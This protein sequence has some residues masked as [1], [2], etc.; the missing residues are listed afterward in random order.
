M[1]SKRPFTWFCSL[2]RVNQ[3]QTCISGGDVRDMRTHRQQR[4]RRFGCIAAAVAATAT[5]EAAVVGWLQLG[6]LWQRK[7]KILSS[8]YQ[9][10]TDR[11]LPYRNRRKVVESK[12]KTQ[13]IQLKQTS[14]KYSNLTW[15]CSSWIYFGGILTKYFRNDFRLPYEGMK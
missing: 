12:R 5:A 10:Q 6:F 14:N 13:S 7:V 8:E 3:L 1:I 4:S 2:L 11:P 9:Q 15:L